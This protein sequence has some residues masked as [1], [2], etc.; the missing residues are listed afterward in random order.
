[1]YLI[2]SV[3]IILF[4]LFYSAIFAASMSINVQYSVFE[5][6]IEDGVYNLLEGKVITILE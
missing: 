3:L 4:L 2:V 6:T 1:M 5:M